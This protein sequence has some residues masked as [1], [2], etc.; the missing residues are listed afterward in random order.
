MDNF[1]WCLGYDMRF[2]LYHTD[3]ATQKRTLRAGSQYLVDVIR[4]HRE[5]HAQK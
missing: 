4:K 5:E 3:Y 1:E 2:G